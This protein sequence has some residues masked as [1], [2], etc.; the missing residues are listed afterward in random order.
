MNK[1][2]MGFCLLLV[3][4]GSIGIVKAL[5]LDLSPAEDQTL[6]TCISSQTKSACYDNAG[7]YVGMYSYVSTRTASI[8]IEGE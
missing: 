3:G 6:V 4:L 1:F 7:K 5:S 8:S 2:L